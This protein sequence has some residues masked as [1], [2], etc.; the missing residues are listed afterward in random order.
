MGIWFAITMLAPKKTQ[1]KVNIKNGSLIDWVTVFN[2][3]IRLAIK[4]WIQQ[5]NA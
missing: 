1:A 2:F 4:S 5:I 3:M